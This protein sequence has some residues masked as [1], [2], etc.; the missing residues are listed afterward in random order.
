MISM[1]NPEVDNYVPK[2]IYPVFKDAY[3]IHRRLIAICQNPEAAQRI[4]EKTPINDEHDE[5][6]VIEEWPVDAVVGKRDIRVVCS[7]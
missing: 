4:L 2:F 6:V 3:G 7:K 1:A 5:E